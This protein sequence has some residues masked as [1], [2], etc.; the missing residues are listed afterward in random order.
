MAA[1]SKN[2]LEILWD[3]LALA[4]QHKDLKW[5]LELIKDIKNHKHK[6]TESCKDYQ[7]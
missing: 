5:T 7:L 2:K 1:D 4:A 3:M 6:I